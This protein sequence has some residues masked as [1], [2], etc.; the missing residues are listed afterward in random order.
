M[1]DCSLSK[2]LVRCGEH[3]F[4]ICEVIKTEPNSTIGERMYIF[5]PCY[6]Q[7]A[8]GISK[9]SGLS[10]EM[11]EQLCSVSNS[12]TL[13]VTK[14]CDEFR[15]YNGL[16]SEITLLP[17]SF[18]KD[19]A[20]FLK[21]NGKMV[22][23]LTNKYGVSADDIRVKRIYIYT[24][25]SK[26]FFQWAMDL[27][28]KAG[29][30]MRTIFNILTWNENYKQ[31]TKNLSRGT[32]T[33]YTSQESVNDLM[34]ELANLRNEKRVNDAINSFNTAQKKLLKVNEL[35]NVDKN[36][37]AKFSKLSDTKKTN[38]IRKVSTIDD[39]QELMRQMRH[40]TSVHFEW[41]KESFMDFLKNVE[42]IS[43]ELIYENDFV[44][45][46]K[47]TDYETI[48]QL[49]K[50]TNWC[51][52]KNKSYWN[53]YIEHNHGKATQYMIFDFSKI[54]DD[55]LSIVGFTTTYNKGIT[56]AHNFVNDNMMDGGSSIS[57]LMLKSY[58]ARFDG[59]NNIYKI[60]QNCGID[61]T[62]VAH[63]DKPHYKWSYEDLMSYLYECVDKNNVDI[64][65]YDS[66]KLVLSVRDENI[67]Y[68]FGDA[69]MD[70]ISCDDY[71]EQHII[72]ADFAMSQYDPNKLT[73]G[74]IYSG[75]ASEEDYCSNMYNEASRVI[76]SNFDS[77]LIEFGV[78]YDIIR[79]TDD[80]SKKIKNAFFSFNINM[81]KDCIKK[82]KNCLHKAMTEYF[83]Q[84]SMYHIIYQSI[85]DLLS[86][87]YLN[88]IYDNGHYLNN[89]LDSNYIGEILKSSFN[90][91]K[92]ASRQL[93][94]NTVMEKP[95][96]E[97]IKAF[98]DEALKNR[99]DVMYVGNYLIIKEIIT[100]E[101]EKN[102]D[103][104][105]I[106]CKILNNIY[107]YGLTGPLIKEFM[108]LIL[109]K[110]NMSEKRE[111]TTYIV[112]YFARFGD[113]EMQDTIK[114]LAEKHSWI[115]LV[116]ESFVKSKKEK[117]AFVASHATASSRRLVERTASIDLT[118]V[119]F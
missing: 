55:K 84:D 91:L 59:S 116:Y 1:S 112:S 98:Y 43:Y 39:Y 74:I 72:F 20:S 88:I 8:Y 26:Y 25:G 107:N 77:K 87:D 68:F 35:S 111:S 49:G 60:L 61:I 58:L 64:I 2:I 104:N 33:A 7:S 79:R 99:N 29:C 109:D 18:D 63:Y 11:S 95:S 105:R 67:K 16:F 97:R 89:Y 3:G 17:S 36:T 62:L 9:L 110:L 47:V 4:S 101:N 42:G 96:E 78:P 13:E 94:R 32:I 31:L 108:Y 73:F 41:S 86:F 117:E 38:F 28:F 19:Y 23:N 10:K 65:K 93:Y 5:N 51:I 70:N 81:I 50:T 76:N 57:A 40:V 34:E 83:D 44:V 54:E 48:K 114:G 85:I 53:N 106:Y 100:H 14:S 21:E 46:V 92:A 27:Y 115:S 75:G 103:F 119:P 66:N 80:I 24:E 6:N 82:N 71:E 102:T 56:S 52:S 15:G 45:L 113:D 22:K 12:R 90:N 30:S 37:L 69:Y 118:G